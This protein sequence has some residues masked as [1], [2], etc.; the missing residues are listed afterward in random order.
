MRDDVLGAIGLADGTADRNQAGG[1]GDD[2]YAAQ[3]RACIFPNVS[4]PIP[5][6]IRANP[7]AQYRVQLSPDGRVTSTTQL[8]SSG[9]PGFDRAVEV[10]IRACSPFPR[11][12]SGRY[13]GHVD[14]D[15]RMYD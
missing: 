8:A 1:G 3:I 4:F 12:P 2:R 10:G 6:R 9:I 5:P 14:V 13:P 11:P 7:T 15:Y